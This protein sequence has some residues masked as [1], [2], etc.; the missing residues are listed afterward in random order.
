MS[1]KWSNEHNAHLYNEYAQMYPLYRETARQ[2]VSLAPIRSD[3]TIVD[4]ACGTGV[5]TEQISQK[6]AQTCQ[7]IGVDLSP[8]MLKYAQSNP[9]LSAVRFYPL[10]AEDLGMVLPAASVDIVLCNSAFWQMQIRDTLT[11]IF[12]LL[13]PD[14]FFLFNFPEKPQPILEDPS[15][16][17]PP[18]RLSMFEIAKQEYG[19]V[20][21]PPA[22]P[23][24]KDLPLEEIKRLIEE[25]GFIL[26]QHYLP[27]TGIE[28]TAADMYAFLRIPSIK[29]LPGLKYATR[30]EILDK[31]FQRLQLSLSQIVDI[32]NWRYCVLQRGHSGNG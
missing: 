21:R 29:V 9:A 20:S 19:Y 27:S 2:L 18:L 24:I 3:I 11:G 17:I 1:S 6:W 28:R 13:K 7:I 8:A 10:R 22:E 23:S 12:H 5:L 16:M 15:R 14:G 32:I 26:W 25:A 4:L 30:L 31:A